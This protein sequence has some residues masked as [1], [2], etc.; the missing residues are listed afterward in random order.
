MRDSARVSL[1][2]RAG[3]LWAAL[4]ALKEAVHRPAA[5]WPS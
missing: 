1:K 4:A 5:D 2:M 3:R